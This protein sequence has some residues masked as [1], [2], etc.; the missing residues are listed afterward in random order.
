MVGGD[1]EGAS[2]VGEGSS[3]CVCVVQRDGDSAV[4]GDDDAVHVGVEGNL[5]AG[6][7]V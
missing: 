1:V 6:G 2:G 5:Y 4:G 3:V 7:D